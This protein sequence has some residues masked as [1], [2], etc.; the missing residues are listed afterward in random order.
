[1]GSRRVGYVWAT[2]VQSDMTEQQVVE[3]KKKIPEQISRKQRTWSEAAFPQVNEKPRE[4]SASPR[5]CRPRPPL[6][7][8][9]ALSA[10]CSG[11]RGGA[12]PKAGGAGAGV[13]TGGA[14]PGGAAAEGSWAAAGRPAAAR[15]AAGRGAGGPGRP[16]G[17]R[18]SHR[19][20]RWA[21]GEGPGT[22]PGMG[23]PAAGS[24][25]PSS[26]VRA[27][28]RRRAAGEPAAGAACS[29]SRPRPWGRCQAAPAGEAYPPRCCSSLSGV[30]WEAGRRTIPEAAKGA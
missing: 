7:E 22:S 4:S 3:G 29:G 13:K 25:G 15:G 26:S 1:M 17:R 6:P 19:G 27:P 12:A 18:E 28:G 11:A 5:G 23:A 20:S 8:A 9:Q 16:A 21:S 14:G 2:Y 10:G 30:T 24:A